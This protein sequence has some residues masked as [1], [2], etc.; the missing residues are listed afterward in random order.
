MDMN[1]EIEAYRISEKSV[2]QQL[3]M[4]LVF[5]KPTATLSLTHSL[6]QKSSTID[7]NHFFGSHFYHHAVVII[8]IL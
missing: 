3:N 6:T 5:Q 1:M 4:K 2:P 7:D 8:I